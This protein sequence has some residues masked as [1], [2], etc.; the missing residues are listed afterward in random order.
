MKSCCIQTRLNENNIKTNLEDHH[1]QCLADKLRYYLD[2]KY[3]EEL[4][5]IPDHI[6]NTLCQNYIF[7]LKSN[8]LDIDE[9]LEDLNINTD[10]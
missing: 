1:C 3:K 9:L 2:V 10:I 6:K 5:D 4:G 8:N 7:K